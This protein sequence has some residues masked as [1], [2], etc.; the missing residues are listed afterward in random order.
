MSVIPIDTYS[1][2]I[3]PIKIP[4]GFHQ[5]RKSN[6][7]ICMK[8]QQTLNN[9]SHLKKEQSWRPHISAFK[10]DY[11]ATVIK[12]AWRWHKDRHITRWNKE[13]KVNPRM[14]HQL[15]FDQGTKN[16]HR[17]KDC[18]FNQRWPENWIITTGQ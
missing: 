14:D 6:L 10:A 8:P 12:P 3:I 5:I 18:L 1:F 9:R 13:P 7:K 2:N 11:K 17:G 15:T 16:T 4:M